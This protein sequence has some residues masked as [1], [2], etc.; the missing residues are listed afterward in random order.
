MRKSMSGGFGAGSGVGI[1]HGC[2]QEPEAHYY[3][4]PSTID[5]LAHTSIYGDRNMEI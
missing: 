1:P 2:N 4:R 5:E 3:A